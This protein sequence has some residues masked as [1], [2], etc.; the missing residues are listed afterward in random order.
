MINENVLSS[1][2]V[3]IPTNNIAADAYLVVA[4]ISAPAL[5]R[6][7]SNCSRLQSSRDFM[8]R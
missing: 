3:N 5:N 2:Y 4:V 8:A 7:I 1:E 6:K